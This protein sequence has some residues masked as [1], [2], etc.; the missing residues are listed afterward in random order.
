MNG[1]LPIEAGHCQQ[2]PTARKE[3]AFYLAGERLGVRFRLVCLPEPHRPIVAAAGQHRVIR[4]PGHVANLVA[5]PAPT[6]GLA[7]RLQTPQAHRL[8]PAAGG[9]RVAI[10]RKRRVA[11]IGRMAARRGALCACGHVVQP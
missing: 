9:K 11:H 4:V 5:V 2:P 6:G 10:R 8:V 3:V 7:S 1:Y